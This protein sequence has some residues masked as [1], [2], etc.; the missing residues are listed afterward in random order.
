ME[1]IIEIRSYSGMRTHTKYNSEYSV[2][3]FEIITTTQSIKLIMADESQCCEA[4]GYFWCNDDPQEFVGAALQGVAMVDTALDVIK[5]EAN[6][7]VEDV[8]IFVNIDTDRG[9]LQFVAYND[10]NGYYGHQVQVECN[11][12]NYSKII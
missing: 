6:S 10:H 3:G 12:L 9:T 7:T 2:S 4:W 8:A 1:T 11:Q 5:L